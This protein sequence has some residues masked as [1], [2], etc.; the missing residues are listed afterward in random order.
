MSLFIA[1]SMH[2]FYHLQ[3][4]SHVRSERTPVT[5][6][7]TGAGRGKRTGETNGGGS[8]GWDA[9]TCGFKG[10]PVLRPESVAGG[11]CFEVLWNLECPI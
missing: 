11:G 2:P 5:G 9:C 6:T 1:I 4:P 7:G 8:K 3:F 10:V